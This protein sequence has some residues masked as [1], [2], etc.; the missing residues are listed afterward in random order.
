MIRRV[1][2]LP[3]SEGPSSTQ[4]VPMSI[5]RSI[6]CSA[7]AVPQDLTV[8]RSSI[9]AIVWTVPMP[10]YGNISVSTSDCDCAL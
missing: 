2:D 3:Q 6:R 5:C 10:Y 8:P 1:V 7:T 4:K 9:D